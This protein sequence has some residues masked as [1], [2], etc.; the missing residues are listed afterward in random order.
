MISPGDRAHSTIARSPMRS[1]SQAE[2]KKADRT[3]E[4]SKIGRK[5][6]VR[7]PL[8]RRS[9]SLAKQLIGRLESISSRPRDDLRQI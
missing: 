1:K 7:S 4:P 2:F 5:I 3:E 9:P 6:P 8:T